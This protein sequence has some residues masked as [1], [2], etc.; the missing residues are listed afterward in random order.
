ML[1]KFGKMQCNLIFH[2][3]Q[4]VFKRESGLFLTPVL[5]YGVTAILT[6]MYGGELLYLRIWREHSARSA[7]I[8]VTVLIHSTITIMRAWFKSTRGKANSRLLGGLATKKSRGTCTIKEFESYYTHFHSCSFFATIANTKLY[9]GYMH[10]VKKFLHC[11]TTWLTS[12][13]SVSEKLK[14][15]LVLCWICDFVLNGAVRFHSCASVDVCR[16]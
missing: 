9:P 15:G 8:I 6:V 12:L 3:H 10:M 11:T 2:L 4:G 13:G 16:C 14:Q 1:H 7:H 5:N